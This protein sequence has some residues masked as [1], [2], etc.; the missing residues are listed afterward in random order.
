MLISDSTDTRPAAAAVAAQTR[1]QAPA[2]PVALAA[3][4]LTVAAIYVLQG[5]LWYFPAKEKLV[6]DGLIAPAGIQKMFAGSFIDSFPGTSVAWGVLGVLQAVI[7]VALAASLLRR[8]FLPGRD[9][10]VL[11]GALSLGLVV[12][13]LLLFGN[14]M[15]A[16]HDSVASL[17]T[18]FGVTVV[19]MAFVAALPRIGLTR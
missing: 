11:L 5:A 9:K 2:G 10:P 8:E 15:I 19:L 18:Y 7:V 14:S 4:W 6:D 17:S 3:Y 12:F 13:A 1:A 16:Q